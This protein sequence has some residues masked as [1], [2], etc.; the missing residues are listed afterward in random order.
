MLADSAVIAQKTSFPNRPKASGKA[1]TK[2]NADRHN[3]E[4]KVNL[5]EDIPTNF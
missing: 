4:E 3:S 2:P 5:L 1:R